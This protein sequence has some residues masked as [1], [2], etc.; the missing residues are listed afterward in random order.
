MRHLIVLALAAA[1]VAAAPAVAHQRD[2]AA[3]N[4]PSTA[5]ENRVHRIQERID[6]LQ[7]RLDE[8]DSRLDDFDSNRRDALDEARTRIEQAARNPSLSPEQIS[9]EVARAVAHADA[10]AKSVAHSASAAHAEMTSVKGRMQSLEQELHT[11]A[12]QTAIAP[13]DDA[14]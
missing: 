13:D 14:G 12:R 3:L 1:T 2:S 11:L 4:C 6:A 9:K 8:L 10:R 7:A 5:Q